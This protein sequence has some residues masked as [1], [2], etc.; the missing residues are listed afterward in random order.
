MAFG[1]EVPFVRPL[2]EGREWAAKF[3]R[4]DETSSVLDF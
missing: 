1:V 3:A 2:T 4:K